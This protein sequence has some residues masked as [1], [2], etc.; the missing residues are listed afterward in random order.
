MAHTYGGDRGDRRNSQ[1][2]GISTPHVDPGHKGSKE[3]MARNAVLHHQGKDGMDSQT[4]AYV[5][6]AASIKTINK[7]SQSVILQA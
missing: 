1:V 4:L 3:G 6:V 5:V 2:Q 7:A